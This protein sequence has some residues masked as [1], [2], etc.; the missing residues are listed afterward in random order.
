MLCE[1]SQDL[2]KARAANHSW[3]IQSYPGRVR[4]PPDILRPLPNADATNR[5]CAAS[6][7][8]NDRYN[9]FVLDFENGIFAR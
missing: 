5:V 6:R 2:I 8:V 3:S 4:M 1:L 7:L 9:D